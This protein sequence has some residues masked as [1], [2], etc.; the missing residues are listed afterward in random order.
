ML[1]LLTDQA[2]PQ[3]AADD[4]LLLDSL[5]RLGISA[6]PAV[7][8]QPQDWRR[9]RGILLRSPW[10]YHLRLPAFLQ[11]L[12][13][14][15]AEGV[16]V[17]NTPALLRWNAEKNYLLELAEAGFPVIPT[18]VLQAGALSGADS[19]WPEVVLKPLVSAG[20]ESTFRLK[21]PG[22][23]PALDPQRWMMLQPYRKEIEEQG[24]YSLIWLGGRYSHTVLKHPS[25]G[26]FLVQEVHGGHTHAADAPPG[27]IDL[28]EALLSW[29]SARFGAPLYARV[30]GIFRNGGL[31][32]ME[33]ELLEP[34]LYLEHRPGAAGDFAE[35][36][37]DWLQN[38]GS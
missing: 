18:R 12:A 33:L 29:I 5:R 19:P 30:D 4:R 23:W 21:Q 37:G 3:L 16:A 36:V 9:Y 26:N 38:L 24:E 17:A 32:L 13:E 2:H 35:A 28:G 7:W 20:G 6:E 14:R 31:E 1:A 22:P 34:S 15:E 10:D 11:W 8:D 27:A 25:H